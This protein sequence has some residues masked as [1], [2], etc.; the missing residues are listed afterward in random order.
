MNFLMLVFVAILAGCYDGT[1]QT[2]QQDTMNYYEVV[3]VGPY[4][5]VGANRYQK[6][7][8]IW[9]ERTEKGEK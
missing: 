1:N 6:P 2:E 9:C 4:T 8:G 3:T 5:C 7:G